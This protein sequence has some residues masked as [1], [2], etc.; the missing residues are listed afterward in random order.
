VLPGPVIF[1]PGVPECFIVARSSCVLHTDPASEGIPVLSVSLR[2][3]EIQDG[4]HDLWSMKSPDVDDLE[5]WT[6]GHNAKC[7]FPPV[8]KQL[9]WAES[10]FVFY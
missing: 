4:R 8:Y 10:K 2:S 6:A 1:L 3:E 9:L 5:T 7:L